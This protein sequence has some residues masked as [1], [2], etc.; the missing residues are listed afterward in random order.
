MKPNK[1]FR[2]VKI[3]ETIE[4]MK[5]RLKTKVSPQIFSYYFIKKG[6]KV[7]GGIIVE[8]AVSSLHEFNKEN[9]INTEL[10][11]GFQKIL[12]FS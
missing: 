4:N 3:H 6:A 9:A 10:K 12:Y 8:A 2:D 7:D 1:F 11:K 5:K